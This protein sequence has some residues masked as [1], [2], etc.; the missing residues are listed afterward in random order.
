MMGNGYRYVCW[1][2]GLFLRPVFGLAVD[3]YTHEDKRVKY[4]LCGI[5]IRLKV[6]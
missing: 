5:L 3:G 4:D 1:E 6:I 2:I